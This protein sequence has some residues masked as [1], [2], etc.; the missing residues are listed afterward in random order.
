MSLRHVLSTALLLGLAAC[1]CGSDSFTQLV[2]PEFEA[3][4]IQPRTSLPPVPVE[5]DS[6]PGARQ[7][8]ILFVLDDGFSMENV[9]LGLIPDNLL[10]DNRVRTNAAQAIMRHLR[11]NILAA[12][13]ARYPGEAFDLAF[14]VGRY[15]D[16]GGAFASSGRNFP[17]DTAARPWVLQMP[18]LRAAHPQF[19]SLFTNSMARKTPG[20][21]RLLIGGVPEIS[22]PNSGIEALWQIATGAGLDADGAGGTL[23]SGA[24][25]AI[26]TQLTPGATG[27][28]PAVTFAD[29]ADGSDPDGRPEFHVRGE[30]GVVTTIP[31]PLGGGAN[32]PL[33]ASGNLGGVGWRNNATRFVILSSDR[34]TVAPFSGPV[35]A[36]VGSTAGTT[37]STVLPATGPR[38]ARLV[39]SAAFDS[40]GPRFGTLAANIAPT[41]SATV[42]ET[43]AA[44]N[45]LHIEVFSLADPIVVQNQVKP[46]GGFDGTPTDINAVRPGVGPGQLGH[47][48]FTPWT[49]LSAVSILT[50]SE[51]LYPDSTL[52]PTLLPAVY[53]LATVWPIDPAAT[54]ISPDVGLNEGLI[55][56]HL[57]EDVA[58]RLVGPPDA[59]A[60]IPAFLPASGGTGVEILPADLPTVSVPVT[61][62]YLP[63]GGFAAN[64][65]A[66]PPAAF[67]S[68]TQPVSIPVYLAGDSAPASS[69]VTFLALNLG[70]AFADP[71]PNLVIAE[72][73]PY[74]IQADFTQLSVVP[75]NASPAAVAAAAQVTAALGSLGL[76]T[77]TDA[78]LLIQ[79]ENLFGSG[80]EAFGS[81]VSVQ[82][83][84]DGCGTVAVPTQP[85]TPLLIGTQPCDPLAP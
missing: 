63:G 36:N 33:I 62:T 6:E 30:G 45:N 53:N 59:T 44:L 81:E 1:G 71:T 54:P 25:G 13:E 70:A 80:T 79:L 82:T 56:D 19:A 61:L 85:A 46:N 40:S 78:T 12:L 41:G 67:A 14:G 76:T 73:L 22:D 72:S 20:D 23:G 60:W 48:T 17:Q 65:T 69:Q 37:P 10:E 2:E 84:T 21:G 75:A 68:Q 83:V 51:I 39:P 32:V 31:D 50:G 57:L 35:P 42:V 28:V 58:Q 24:P 49:W 55:T 29:T 27:D 9:F 26:A 64:L 66:L 16:Y 7:I 15:E 77:L 74:R 52:T 3:A 4:T 34:A 11:A 18:I 38:S 8:D 5:S 47:P 43:I